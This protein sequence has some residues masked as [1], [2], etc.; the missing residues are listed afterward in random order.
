MSFLD[1]LIT[2]ENKPKMFEFTSVSDK[3]LPSVQ[4][5]QL[6]NNTIYIKKHDPYGF[7]TVNFDKGGM[8][9]YLQGHFLSDVEARKA[10]MKYLERKKRLKEI[11]NV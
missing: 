3:D 7:W 10:V 8:P 11:K 1:S 6:S 9:E 5:I 2:G 4:T